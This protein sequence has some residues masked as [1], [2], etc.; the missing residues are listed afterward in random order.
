EWEMEIQMPCGATQGGPLDPATEA[1]PCAFNTGMVLDGLC[2]AFEATN[3]TRF[4]A[5]ARRAADYLT[6]DMNGEGYF[7]TNGKF[8]K[9]GIIKTYNC[10]CAWGLYRLG[11]LVGD[12]VYEHH[13]I[14]AVEAAIRQQQPNGW[15]ANNC[16]TRSNAPLLHTIA[17]TMQGILEVGILAG[18][19][20]FVDAVRLGIAPLIK[21]IERNA[22]LPGR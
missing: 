4:L 17:Y 14:R 7:K 16:L 10:L 1:T 21:R 6:S 20:D 9:P 13:A 8:V 2:S 3:D 11:L 15:F 19:Q 12:A 18:R 22:F 5:A